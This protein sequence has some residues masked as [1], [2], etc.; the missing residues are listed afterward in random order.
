M[1]ISPQPKFGDAERM[2]V[3]T[4]L[5]TAKERCGRYGLL[6]TMHALD[7]ALQVAGYE[8]A[9]ILEGD[10]AAREG[11]RKEELTMTTDATDFD[12]LAQEI[13]NDPD[14]RAAER[15]NAIRHA[16]AAAIDLGRQAKGWSLRKFA[17]EIGT[18]LSQVQRLLQRERGGS[19]TLWTI[20]RA[21][22]KLDLQ[23]SV[24]VRAGIAR[25]DT[26]PRALFRS[27]RIPSAPTGRYRSSCER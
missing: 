18:S 10:Q 22:D 16:I 2:R 17:D 3:V 15:E 6:R 11:R 27:R 26:V 24:Q 13:R 19:L 9:D 20:C 14:A 21:A 25:V 1:Y 12:A 4:D 8:M 7:E 5:V 23:V